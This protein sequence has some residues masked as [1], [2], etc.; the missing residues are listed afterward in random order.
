MITVHQLHLSPFNE[1]VTRQLNYKGIPFEERFWK[2]GEMKQVKGFNPTGKLPFLEH[3]GRFICDSTDIVYYL[4]EVF[5]D[6]PMIP[7]DRRLAA[8]MH[9]IEDWADESLY[10]YEMHLRFGTPGN[11]E[12]NLPR[13]V[14]REN[15]F[16]RWLM[17]KIGSRSIRKITRNQGLGKKSLDQI[18][19]DTDRH[20]KAVEDM[21]GEN[22]W[23][24]GE[25]PT[26]ADLAV[27]GMFKA[28]ADA[29]MAHALIQKYPAVPAW[30]TRVEQTTGKRATG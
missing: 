10:F 12:R 14:E 2:I 5:P 11:A 21:L 3:N 6:N 30:M 18:L 25:G 23:L 27:Y 29:D 24:L 17:P 9:A 13:M 4:E 20:V 28:L 7:G 22:D 8:I 19:V 16:L 15:A 1:K 26:L